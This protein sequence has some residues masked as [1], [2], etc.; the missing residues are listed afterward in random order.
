MSIMHQQMQPIVRQFSAMCASADSAFLFSE[1]GSAGLAAS[2]AV[3]LVRAHLDISPA[4][5]CP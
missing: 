3:D 4:I 1:A 2:T 5:E